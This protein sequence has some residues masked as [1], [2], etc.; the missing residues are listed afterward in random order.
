MITIWKHI[1]NDE[2]NKVEMPKGATVLHFDNQR[3]TFCIW[4]AHDDGTHETEVRTFVIVGTGH[5]ADIDVERYIG[6]ALFS[7]GSFVFHL[8][9]AT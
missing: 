4:E 2:I 8:F 5:S 3:E 6:T 1:L 7:G 9:E